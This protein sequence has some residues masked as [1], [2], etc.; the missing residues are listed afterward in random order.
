MNWK[1]TTFQG[2]GKAY[3]KYDPTF[4]Y[5]IRAENFGYGLVLKTNNGPALCGG[6]LLR[7]GYFHFMRMQLGFQEM[8][9]FMQSSHPKG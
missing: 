1:G 7:C 9:N 6:D 4:C 2:T 5:R 3:K 8:S